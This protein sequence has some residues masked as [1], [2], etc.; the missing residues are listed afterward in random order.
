EFSADT[1]EGYSSEQV[2]DTQLAADTGT[3]G[4][5]ERLY[6]VKAMTAKVRVEL[7]F[8]DLAS[9]DERVGVAEAHREVKTEGNSG[10]IHI[11]PQLQ[12]LESVA[13]E[14]FHNFFEKYD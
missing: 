13:N 2:V 6:K 5:T 9:G 3:D 11:P 14:A 10:G 4:R 7:Q 8:A 12:F 1:R